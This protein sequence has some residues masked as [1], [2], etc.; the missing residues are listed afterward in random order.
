[1]NVY[2]V[3]LLKISVRNDMKLEYDP[4]L[5]EEVI[6]RELTAREEK[7][8][9]AFALEYHS[10]VDPVYEN[11]PSEERASQFRKIE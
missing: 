7:G 9:F 2:P 11:F 8:D 4:G 10:S 1:M 5:I 3:R 6:F